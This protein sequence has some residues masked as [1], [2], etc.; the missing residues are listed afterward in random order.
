[1]LGQTLTGN[2]T[3]ATGW[4]RYEML[5]QTLTGKATQATGEGRFEIYP[6][7]KVLHRWVFGSIL[8]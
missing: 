3:Q 1:M 8:S 4:G 7:K 5:G 6:V 2:A